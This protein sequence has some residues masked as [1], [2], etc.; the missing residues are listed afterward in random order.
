MP[1]KASVRSLNQRVEGLNRWRDHYNPLRGLTILRAVGLLEQWRRG[2]FADPLWTLFHIED[3][4]PDLLALIERRTS[5]IGQL[6]WQIKVVDE[7]DRPQDFSQELADEQRGALR[8]AYDK[9]DNLYE[10]IEHLELAS[11]RGFAHLQPQI[12]SGGGEPIATVLGADHFDCLDPWNFARDGMYG[13]WYWNPQARTTT[14]RA[15]GDAARLE[16]GDTILREVRR[17]IGRVALVKKIRSDLSEKDWDAFI[18]IYGVPASIIIG[19]A[20]LS[21][22]ALSEFEDA[23]A[24]VADGG[25]GVL[26][27]GSTV[28]RAEGVRGVSPFKAR[29]DHL[30]E[31][32]VLAGTGGMLTMLTASGSGTLAG[33]AHQETFEIIAR[34]EAKKISEVLQRQFDTRILDALFPGQPHLVYFELSANEEQ[35]VGDILDQAVKAREAGYTIDQSDLQERTGFKLIPSPAVSV[36][37]GGNGSGAVMPQGRLLNRSAGP[38]PDEVGDLL[39]EAS[40]ELSK[41][42]RADLKALAEPLLAIYGKAEGDGVTAE[43]LAQEL[44]DLQARLPEILKEINA[45][46]AT[47]AVFERLMAAA[48]G[49]GIESEAAAK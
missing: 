29:L 39:A 36:P 6:D 44:K 26:P 1:V 15:L 37:A 46:P 34:A 22:T 3:T 5:A 47:A 41:A 8:A 17:V 20:D 11:F 45:D 30:S 38:D 19:P 4:D 33:G 28:D 48:L 9:I 35:D 43:Q 13:A 25:S 10:A 31:K 32:L 40:M 23:A 27:N 21:D 24:D 12:R 2:E 14:A 42:Q 49:N 16:P 7:D 18:E